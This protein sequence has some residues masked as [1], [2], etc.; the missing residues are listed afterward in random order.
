MQ[1]RVY[2]THYRYRTI[3]VWLRR[4]ALHRRLRKCEDKWISIYLYLL[5]VLTARRHVTCERYM[6]ISIWSTKKSTELNTGD[7]RHIRW[8]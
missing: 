4:L 5:T 8:G 6:W 7:A 3:I 1:P 2:N